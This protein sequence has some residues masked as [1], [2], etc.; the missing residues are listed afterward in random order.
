M[1][2]RQNVPNQDT[3]ESDLYLIRASVVTGF[4]LALLITAAIATAG[5]GAPSNGGTRAAFRATSAVAS[6]SVTVRI[7][8]AAT[9]D[10]DSKKPEGSQNGGGQK[11]Y[12]TLLINGEQLPAI[13]VE[14][15]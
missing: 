3:S 6:A 11:H 1:L 5:S 12:R 15:P 2:V 10:F 4:M 8:E 9:I 14:F 13:L 7:I